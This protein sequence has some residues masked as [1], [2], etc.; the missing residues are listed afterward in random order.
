MPLFVICSN[1]II[2][3]ILRYAARLSAINSGD[4]VSRIQPAAAAANLFPVYDV[5][6]AGSMVR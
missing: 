3:T 4:T 6:Y 2:C 1:P 5:G